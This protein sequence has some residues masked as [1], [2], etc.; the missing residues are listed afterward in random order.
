M[1]DFNSNP[2]T[3]PSITT[4]SSI[5]IDAKILVHILSRLV[6]CYFSPSTLHCA[7]TLILCVDYHHLFLSFALHKHTLLLSSSWELEH[8]CSR[9]SERTRAINFFKTSK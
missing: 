3:R 4:N 7:Q 9:K 5:H 8:K 1:T 2:S 6:K